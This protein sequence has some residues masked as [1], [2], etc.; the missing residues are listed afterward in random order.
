M[1][2]IIVTPLGEDAFGVEVRGDGATSTNHRVT[3]PE[4][5]VE[6]L[7]LAEVDPERLVRES[8]AF[9]LEREPSTSILPEFSLEEIG[10]FFPEY[11]QELPTRLA[12]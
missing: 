1:S 5:M 6:E 11:F 8:I 2:E 9:L 3:V 4:G 10:G 12:P 7:D